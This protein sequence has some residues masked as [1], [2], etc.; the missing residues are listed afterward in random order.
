MLKSFGWTPLSYNVWHTHV[1]D[2][3]CIINSKEQST[4]TVINALIDRLLDAE[5]AQMHY[6]GQGMQGGVD[7]NTTSQWHNSSLISYPQMCA[8]ETILTA[9]FWRNL[10]VHQF[11]PDVCKFCDRCGGNEFDTALHCFWS[12]TA[13]ASIEDE[14]VAKT[15]SLVVD[16]EMHFQGLCP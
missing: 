5:R 13:N 2:T 16:A 10:R 15:Q 12:C 14:A 3:S 11:R 9:S 4:K 7:W 8:L 6:C 1:L